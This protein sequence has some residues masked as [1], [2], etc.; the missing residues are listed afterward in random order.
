M[1]LCLV[2]DVWDKG[3]LHKLGD[4]PWVISTLMW[5][6][7]IPL[8][9]RYLSARLHGNMSHKTII[10]IFTT[11]KTSTLSTNLHKYIH[12]GKQLCV[13]RQ[14]AIQFVP[15]FCYKPLGKFPLKHYNGTPEERSMQKQLEHQWWWDLVWYIGNTH[16]KERQICLQNITNHYL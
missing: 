13:N 10:L 2:S 3:V 9:H 14:P 5:W 11:V 7:Y 1:W 8:K 4:W 16:I 6:V 12:L 15:W